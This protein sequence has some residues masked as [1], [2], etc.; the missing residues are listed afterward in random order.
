M[1]HPTVAE[2][3]ANPSIV[4]VLVYAG[5]EGE[6]VVHQGAPYRLHALASLRARGM[7]HHLTVTKAT[8]TVGD[9]TDYFTGD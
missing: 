1:S 5:Q 8:R 6:V 9:G 2:V 4:P 7:G 3:L